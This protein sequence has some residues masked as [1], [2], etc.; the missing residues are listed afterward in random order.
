MNEIFTFI[1][2]KISRKVAKR[3][4]DIDIPCFEKTLLLSI[5]SQDEVEGIKKNEKQKSPR[6]DGLTNKI[7]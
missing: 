2:H 6:Y 7:L 5:T 3:Q 4:H 1:S